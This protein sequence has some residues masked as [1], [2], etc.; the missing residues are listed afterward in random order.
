MSDPKRMA[1][2]LASGTELLATKVV[3]FSADQVSAM[4]A[5]RAKAAQSMGGVSTGISFWG[6][7]EW[8]IGGALLLGAIEGA[9]T[10]AAN[11]EGLA[12]LEQAQAMEQ[13]IKASGFLMPVSSIENVHSPHPRLWSSSIER[14]KKVVLRGK[15]T[16]ERAA[17]VRQYNIQNGDLDDDDEA[18]VNAIDTLVF[19]GDAFVMLELADGSMTTV[20]WDAVVQY[21]IVE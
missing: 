10:K 20:K 14:K 12:A 6:S 19:D 1:L 8:A 13:R 4:L 18:L 16:S 7:P 3:L 21:R 17:L 9:L 11:R 5:L 15:S 2:T